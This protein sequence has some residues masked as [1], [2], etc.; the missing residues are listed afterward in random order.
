[1][2]NMSDDFEIVDYAETTLSAAEVREWLQPT[3]F[4]AESG[5]FRRHLSL[6]VP[7]TGLWIC[8]T[9]EYRAW[10]DSDNHGSLWIKGI[11]GAGKVGHRRITCPP[12]QHHGAVPHW[13]VQLLP[14]SPKLQFILHARPEK[15]AK[16]AETSEHDLFQDF[17]DQLNRLATYRPALL[18]LLMTSRPKRHLQSALRDSSIVH[19]SL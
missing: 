4:N 6:P 11:P 17:L 2:E 5:E 13:H 16:L 10:H 19:I 18:K 1:A 12:P 7:D 3:D 15:R 14:H 8:D 9:Q